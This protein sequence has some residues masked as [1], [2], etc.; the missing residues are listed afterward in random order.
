MRDLHTLDAYRLKG[1]ELA[2]YGVN[3]DGGNGIFKVFVNG[4]SFR[5]IASDGGGWEHVSVSPCNRKRQNCPTWEEMCAIKD[6]FFEPEECVMQL[7]PPKSDYVNMHP[8]CLHLWKPT[9]GTEIP[10]PPS[11]YVGI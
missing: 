8:Y 4:R 3:G 11:I 1:D 2:Y 7:H 6:M 10:R 5:V 9:G